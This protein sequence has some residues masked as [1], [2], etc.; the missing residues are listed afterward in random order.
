[1]MPGCH[2]SL[3]V[4]R[5]GVLLATEGG[6]SYC[7]TARFVGCN[8]TTIAAW[9]K[10]ASLEGMAE[11]SYERDLVIENR[12]LRK[13]LADS[14]AENEFL[15]KAKAFFEDDNKPNGSNS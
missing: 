11:N 3:S 5:L 14:K 10:Q 8:D 1:M 4:R 6:W 12:R 2:Y 7:R 13:E 9:V 15:K